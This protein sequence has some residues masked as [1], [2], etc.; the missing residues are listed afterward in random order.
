LAKKLA[1]DNAMKNDKEQIVGNNPLDGSS[2][3]DE[4]IKKKKKKKKKTREEEG[5]VMVVEESVVTTKS[6]MDQVKS[7]KEPVDVFDELDM[8]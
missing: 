1:I 6:K 8:L 3:S 7:K 4:P 2:S 5:E